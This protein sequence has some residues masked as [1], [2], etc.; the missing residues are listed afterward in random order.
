MSSQ[1]QNKIQ[2]IIAFTIIIIVIVGSIQL[3][4]LFVDYLRVKIGIPINSSDITTNNTNSSTS[5]SNISSIDLPDIVI[6]N[7]PDN[8][9]E[10]KNLDKFDE[11]S[12]SEGYNIN[13]NPYTDFY[14]NSF[15]IA[16]RGEFRYLYLEVDG[17]ILDNQPKL[18]S[19]AIDKISGILNGVRSGINRLDIDATKQKGGVFYDK[20]NFKIDL[21]GDTFISSSNEELISEKS[22]TKRV[23]FWD[24]T[25]APP[26][27]TFRFLVAPLNEQGVYG[28]VN[29][30][31]IKLKYKCEQ[32]GGCESTLCNKDELT[33]VCLSR[34]FGIEA[35]KEW[36]VNHPD[37][38]GCENL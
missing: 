11:V 8:D 12:V 17:D 31:S 23:V 26:P 3:I 38:S 25:I 1:K 7:T 27:S 34:S 10:N 30:N 37:V 18:V 21:L 15:K 6:P 22:L 29:I 36:C 32:V 19:V 28:N 14:N 2:S 35:A 4:G 13:D 24:D 33:T 16:V 9:D 5:T 20:I